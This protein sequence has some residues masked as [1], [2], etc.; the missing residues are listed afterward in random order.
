MNIE[1]IHQTQPAAIPALRTLLKLTKPGVTLLLVFTAVATAVAA[2]GPWVDPL[3]L[4]LL[5]LSG[6]LAAGGA[7]AVNHYLERDLDGRMPRTAGRPLP[8][9]ELAEPGIALA[10]G[11]G[12]AALGLW[13]SHLYLPPETTLFTLL[14][15]VVYV[16]VY[17]ML[18]KRRTP[19]NVV[20]GGAAGVFPVLAGWAVF[21]VDWP[22]L[23][24]AL[25]LVVFFW[26]PAHF[27]AFA[28]RHQ[29]DYGQADFP[30][31]PNILGRRRTAPFIFV[32][33]LAAVAASLVAFTG[34]PWLL[35]A[36]SGTFF[37]GMCVFLWLKP[38]EKRAYLLYKASNYY[39]M[40]VFGG[41]LFV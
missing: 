21:R 33:A 32:H 39:L 22:L 34:L 17:T 23:P 30:M 35:A 31:L 20:I 1:P 25:A 14:G 13:I 37:L 40:V 4:F 7:G 2:G 38:T 26:T 15:I 6:G 18:L 9:G 29:A 5:A 36:V 16:P 8:A 24:V 41:V 12:L 10:W 28:I 19:L 11:A 3:K 27:W